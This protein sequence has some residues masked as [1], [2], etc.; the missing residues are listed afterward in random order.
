MD[1]PIFQRHAVQKRLQR[2]SG[3]TL[4]LHHV[5]IAKAFLIAKIRSTNV[6]P[7]PHV[8][9]VHHQHRHGTV[10]GQ[11]VTVTA[12]IVF[13][14][15]LQIA[16]HGGM[17]QAGIRMTLHQGT[18]QQG[19]RLGWPQRAGLHG[20]LHGIV[21]RALIPHPQRRHALEHLVP[22]HLRTLGIAIGPDA[23]R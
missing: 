2:R 14:I 5:Q 9:V 8:P 20:F 7:H 3:G 22:R 1:Q 10:L 13:Q 19:R 17:D 11:P 4:G 12:D 6:R 15:A 16:V 21:H 18:G 23:G